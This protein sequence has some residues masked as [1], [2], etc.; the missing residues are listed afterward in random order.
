MHIKSGSILE[1]NKLSIIFMEIPCNYQYDNL[2]SKTLILT[3]TSVQMDFQSQLNISG[4]NTEYYGSVLFTMLAWSS[5]PLFLNPFSN[6]LH[7][8]LFSDLFHLNV[9]HQSQSIQTITEYLVMPQKCL[10]NFKPKTC[11]VNCTLILCSL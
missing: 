5:W 6:K 7:V 3:L 2:S 4:I 9:K 11:S 1:I 8:S 10:Y